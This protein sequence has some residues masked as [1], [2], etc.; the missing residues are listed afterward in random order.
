MDSS[1]TSACYRENGEE[2]G[3]GG[4]EGAGVVLPRRRGGAEGELFDEKWRRKRGRP[5]VRFQPLRPCASAGVPP[6]L[7]NVANYR[8]ALTD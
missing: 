4:A 8:S 5:V 3:A 1:D 7:W 2:A 6:R